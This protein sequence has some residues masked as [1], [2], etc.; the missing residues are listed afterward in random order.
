MTSETLPSLVRKELAKFSLDPEVFRVLSVQMFML[1]FEFQLLFPLLLLLPISPN[2]HSRM[3]EAFVQVEDYLTKISTCVL[4]EG[5]K[6]RQLKTIIGPII[7]EF[8]NDEDLS[9]LT[10]FPPTT[11]TFSL[12][13]VQIF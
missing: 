8:V 1:P 4:E 12:G 3:A 5:G 2:K 9:E 7:E 13:M 6:S 10:L 11:S